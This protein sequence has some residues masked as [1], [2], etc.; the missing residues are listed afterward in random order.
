M[1]NKTTLC[2]K[3]CSSS[4]Y[5]KFKP[6]VK[7]RG[8]VCECSE[9]KC[10][11]TWPWPA[12]WTSRAQALQE[13]RLRKRRLVLR[14]NLPGLFF[15]PEIAVLCSLLSHVSR[16]TDLSCL[17]LKQCRLEVGEVDIVPC[18]FTAAVANSGLCK[19]HVSWLKRDWEKHG[20]V[21]RRSATLIVEFLLVALVKGC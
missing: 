17:A 6:H 8:S 9:I 13:W 19:N 14:A 7:K 20:S 5:L 16:K 11:Y 21:R 3:R 2:H 15:S 18:G 4:F 1:I 12:A 10:V